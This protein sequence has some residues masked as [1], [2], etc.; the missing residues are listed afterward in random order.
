MNKSL[1][2]CIRCCGG[3]V[4]DVLSPNNVREVGEL[5]NREGGE[6]TGR[7]ARLKRLDTT[8]SIEP[9]IQTSRRRFTRPCYNAATILAALRALRNAQPTNKAVLGIHVTLY[10]IQFARAEQLNLCVSRPN[11]NV[12]QTLRSLQNVFGEDTIKLASQVKVSRR[13]RVLKEWRDAS[14]WH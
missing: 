13:Q 11:A 2:D 3:P 4:Y 7:E 10:G 1:T 5:A 12:D 14:G 8:D 9:Q 6:T